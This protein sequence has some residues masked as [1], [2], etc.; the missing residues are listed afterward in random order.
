MSRKHLHRYLSEAEF[1][2]NSRGLNDGE[3]TVKLIQAA[4]HRRLT[5]KQQTSKNRD[6]KGRF[7]DR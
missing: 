3:R 2:Y 6:D 7:T 4:D 5:Y 1:K